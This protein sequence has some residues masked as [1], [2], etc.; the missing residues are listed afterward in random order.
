VH[1]VTD[2]RAEGDGIKKPVVLD[3]IRR[4]Q[5][6]GERTI[7]PKLETIRAAFCTPAPSTDD[8]GESEN[9]RFLNTV[10]EIRVERE[11]HRAAHPHR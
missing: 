1:T 3:L 5:E 6:M 4:F 8:S 10:P 2:M 11:A 7:D 9:A